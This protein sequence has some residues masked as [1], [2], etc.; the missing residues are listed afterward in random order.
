MTLRSSA[1]DLAVEQADPGEDVAACRLPLAPPPPATATARLGLG[2]AS[3]RAR[4][5]PRRSPRRSLRSSPGRRSVVR[6][7]RPA[8]SWP[9]GAGRAG[10]TRTPNRRFWRPGLYQLSYCP[11]GP[12]PA[13]PG[14]RPCRLRARP[15]QAPSIRGRRDRANPRRTARDRPRAERRAGRPGGPHAGPDRCGTMAAWPVRTASLRTASAPSP[16]PPPWPS[17]PRPRR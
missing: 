16:S 8:P 1:I 7:R 14:V 5:S 13:D 15:A 6:I 3:R 9:V 10:G 17:T 4:S 12:E 11:R 2:E